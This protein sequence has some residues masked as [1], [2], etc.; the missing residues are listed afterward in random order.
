MCDGKELKTCVICDMCTKLNLDPAVCEN[1]GKSYCY[2]C[3]KKWVEEGSGCFKCGSKKYTKKTPPMYDDLLGI[4][5]FD[6][7]YSKNEMPFP[8]CTKLAMPY[9][10]AIEHIKTCNCAVKSCEN[11]KCSFR[12]ML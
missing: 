6:C 11:S 5:K 9:K 4:V 7:P 3:F 1:C 8:I 10:E 2:P 12:G